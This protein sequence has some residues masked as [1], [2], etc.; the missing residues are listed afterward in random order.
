METTSQIGPHPLS[1]SDRAV[2]AHD[3]LELLPFIVPLA[4][5]HIAFT[6]A[7]VGLSLQAI[8]FGASGFQ[9]GLIVSLLAALP[10]VLSVP[11][12]RINDRIGDRLPGAVSMGIVAAGCVLVYWTHSLPLLF[13][14][15]VIIGLGFMGA[16]LSMNNAVGKAAAPEQ[17]TRAYSL[18]ALGFSIASVCG[19][20]FMGFGI[21]WLGHGTAFL[22]L[23]TFPVLA[24]AI[25]LSLQVERAVP[26]PAT[27]A[28]GS[29]RVLDLLRYQ[30]LQRA[31]LMGTLC[32]MGWDMFAFL[33]PLE[34]T[35]IGLSASTIGLIMS[36]FAV[37]TF[38]VRL[39]LPRMVASTGEF[40]V[41]GVSMMAVAV[42]YMLWP[43]FHNPY[44][45][46]GLAFALGLTLGVAQPLVMSIVHSAAPESRSGEA[47]GI[48]VTIM[49]GS[50]TFLPLTFGGLSAAVGTAGPL[51][52][53]FGLLMGGVGLAVLR[54]GKSEREQES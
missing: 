13:G 6:G 18:V 27:A 49:S 35:R 11:M 2:S 41:M 50:Q 53:G 5:T 8:Q 46:V 24:L 34:G 38:L 19:P 23:A 22:A 51:F 9:V 4:L 44:V 26:Q 21:D 45:L 12:G 43:M 37:A 7:R 20:L 29:R 40:T 32:S 28:Q 16:H 31:F 3:P 33:V 17:R 15:S 52:W 54:W 14:C 25:G 1:D 36:S 30:P 10:L 47:V 39:A 48:R 42:L